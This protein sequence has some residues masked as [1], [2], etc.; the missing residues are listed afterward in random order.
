MRRILTVQMAKVLMGY[1]LWGM[2]V[3][4][5]IAR[6]RRLDWTWT[7]IRGWCSIRCVCVCVCVRR[8]YTYYYHQSAPLVMTVGEISFSKLGC[9]FS[10]VCVCACD[11][12]WRNIARDNRFWKDEKITGRLT[13]KKKFESAMPA[14]ATLT[15]CFHMLILENDARSGNGRKFDFDVRRKVSHADSNIS[16]H[17]QCFMNVLLH[18]S[19]RFVYYNTRNAYFTWRTENHLTSPLFV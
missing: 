5:V 4:D 13:A 3:D 6:S 11:L 7:A 14:D 16:A 10:S 8:S 2:D 9:A 19:Y 18:Q 15:F 12:L 1:G 17:C